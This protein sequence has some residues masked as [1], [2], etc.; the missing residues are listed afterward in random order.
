MKMATKVG[1]YSAT[2]E[3]V[4]VASGRDRKI[5]AVLKTNQIVTFVPVPSEKKINGNIKSSFFSEP[6]F[7]FFFFFSNM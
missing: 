4:T 2:H 6:F 5:W 3:S 1:M 7:N